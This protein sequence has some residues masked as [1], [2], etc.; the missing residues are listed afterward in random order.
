MPTVQPP[1]RYSPIPH[2]GRELTNRPNVL[3]MALG[4]AVR[5]YAVREGLARYAPYESEGSERRSIGSISVTADA[6]WNATLTVPTTGDVAFL[7]LERQGALPAGYRGA[8]ETA[9]FS[10]PIAEAEAVVDLLAGIV[11][12]ARRDGVLPAR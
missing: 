2:Q 9:A 11:A 12:Q 8:E 7:Q 10:L 6:H 3:G 5:L 1:L 4:R